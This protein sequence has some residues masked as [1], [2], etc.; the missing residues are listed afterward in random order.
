[1]TGF[2]IGTIFGCIVTVSV[3]SILLVSKE[4]KVDI[5]LYDRNKVTLKDCDIMYMRGYTT[6]LDSGELLGFTKEY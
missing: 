3:M 6:V 2:I 5:L 4:D 1:M